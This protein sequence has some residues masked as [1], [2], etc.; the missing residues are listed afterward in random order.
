[1]GTSIAFNTLSDHGT[2]T[3]VFVAVA[4]IISYLFSSIR[5]LSRIGWL[6]WVGT[7]SVIT[8]IFLVTIAVTLQDHPSSVKLA[9]GQAWKSD[10]KLVNT[11]SFTDG[12]SA[13]STLIFAYAGTPGFFNI[14]AEMRTPKNYHRSLMACQGIITA[15]Y[16][17]IGTIMYYYC[18][19]YISSPALGS[20]GPL[21]KKVGYGISLPGLLVSGIVLAHVSFG[22]FAIQLHFKADIGQDASQARFRSSP[23]RNRAPHVQ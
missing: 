18:G 16:I 1:M 3:T 9:P 20:A 14:V 2:C 10:Y 21:I 19:S 11:P 17:I 8:S 6:A 15:V 7:M 23:P 12:I 22:H 13:I 4:A 5:T